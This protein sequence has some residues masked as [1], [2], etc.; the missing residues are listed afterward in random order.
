MNK[1]DFCN[2]KNSNQLKCQICDECTL[3]VTN[4]EDLNKLKHVK[5][6]KSTTYKRAVNYS[7]HE[8]Q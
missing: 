4:A 7:Q 8:K 5:I 2:F 1:Y 3:T 6:I